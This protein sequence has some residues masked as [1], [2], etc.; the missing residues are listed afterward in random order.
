MKCPSRGASR[1][2]RSEN[3]REGARGTDNIMATER[4]CCSELGVGTWGWVV[5]VGLNLGLGVG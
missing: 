5:V 3:E 1:A 2:R 4:I